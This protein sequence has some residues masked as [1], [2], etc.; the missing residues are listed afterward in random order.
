[1][2]ILL[3]VVN[4]L[5][6]LSTRTS[7]IGFFIRQLANIVEIIVDRDHSTHLRRYHSPVMHRVHGPLAD[8]RCR[9]RRR[10]Q[11]PRDRE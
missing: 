1:M 6:C 9:R 3:K 2:K 4:A 11:Q 8:P 7:V 5:P 10:L